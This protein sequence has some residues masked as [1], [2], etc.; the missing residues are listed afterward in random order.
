MVLTE[1]H[2]TIDNVRGEKY[3]KSF[4]FYEQHLLPDKQYDCFQKAMKCIYGGT[5]WPLLVTR[6]FGVSDIRTFLVAM[7]LHLV[8]I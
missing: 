4:T 7:D 6:I 5:P 2:C 8:H 1:F 3:S